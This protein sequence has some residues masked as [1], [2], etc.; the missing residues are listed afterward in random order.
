MSLPSYAALG[1]RARDIGAD[2]Q[3]L[4][5]DLE[6]E[7]LTIPYGLYQGAR[8]LEGLAYILTRSK[9]PEQT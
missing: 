9:P 5:R 8:A 7:H 4:I 2:L 6:T 3:D 1:R